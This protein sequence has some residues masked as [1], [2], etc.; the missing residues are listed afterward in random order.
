VVFTEMFGGST[1]G[2]SRTGKAMNEATPITLRM[3]AAT[4]AKTGRRTEMSES[5][6]TRLA[7]SA[8]PD[9]QGP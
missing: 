6:M 3:I 7:S 4:A 8:A 5:I 2:S 1:F 9:H